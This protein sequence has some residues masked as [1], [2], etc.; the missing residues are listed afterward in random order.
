MLIRRRPEMGTGQPGRHE[1]FTVSL[2]GTGVIFAVKGTVRGEDVAVGVVEGGL[3]MD[4]D[5]AV[6]TGAGSDWPHPASAG[7]ETTASARIDHTRVAFIPPGSPMPEPDQKPT[8]NDELFGMED[9][10]AGRP[11]RPTWPVFLGR[12]PTLRDRFLAG[13][14]FALFVIIDMIVMFPQLSSPAVSTLPQAVVLL[15]VAFGL[16]SLLAWGVGD[17][18]RPFGFGLMAG[19][20]LLT[21][22]SLGIL[23]GLT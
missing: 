12:P 20:V 13:S 11:D 3:E 16:G 14:G 17:G 6:G 19:W 2:D 1:D 15:A 4:G 7:P 5:D 18:W 8:L 21:L 10:A 23:T 22:L 9:K